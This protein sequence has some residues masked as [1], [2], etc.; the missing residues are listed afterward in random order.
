MLT[1]E[2]DDDKSKIRSKKIRYKLRKKNARC[3]GCLLSCGGCRA[4]S[5]R[6][7]GRLLLWLCAFVVITGL[8]IAFMQSNHLHDAFSWCKSV[9]SKDDAKRQTESD[10]TTQQSDNTTMTSLPGDNVTITTATP[11][12]VDCHTTMK[13]G[14]GICASCHREYIMFENPDRIRMRIYSALYKTLVLSMQ[15]SVLTEMF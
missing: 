7:W 13:F 1:R 9:D 5:C 8:L 14:I 6:W 12:T 11:H 15:S 10:A 4:L 2:A 3:C